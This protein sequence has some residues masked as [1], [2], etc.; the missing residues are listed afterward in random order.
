MSDDDE[1]GGLFG[2]AAS[3]GRSVRDNASDNES[4]SS[5]RAAS[6]PS[7]KSAKQPSSPKAPASKRQKKADGTPQKSAPR[8]PRKP[9]Q[10]PNTVDEASLKV[11]EV[12]ELAGGK[13]VRI[14]RLPRSRR[15]YVL[16]GI[17]LRD[18]SK[19][20]DQV[21]FWTEL[22]DAV[23]SKPKKVPEDGLSNIIFVR[24]QKKN[25]K[26]GPEISAFYSGGCLLLP[27][28]KWVLD[29]YAKISSILSRWI[30]DITDLHN[31]LTKIMKK[32]KAAADG[33][34]KFTEDDHK[35]HEQ[36]FLRLEDILDESNKARMYTALDL[37]L[38]FTLPPELLAHLRKLFGVSLRNH[39]DVLAGR[40][41]AAKTK[42]SKS[43]IE[44]VTTNPSR[45]PP[46]PGSVEAM[47]VQQEFKRKNA[48]WVQKVVDSMVR[49]GKVNLTEEMMKTPG[50]LFKSFGGESALAGI[51]AK[52]VKQQDGGSVFA[53][54]D[55]EELLR[56]Y[57][58]S[59]ET[60]LKIICL[61]SPTFVEFAFRHR[62]QLDHPE[63]E[64][65]A[66]ESK[67]GADEESGNSLISDVE[68]AMKTDADDD[69]GSRPEEKR[70][71]AAIAAAASSSSSAGKKRKHESSDD[72]SESDVAADRKRREEMMARKKREEKKKAEEFEKAFPIAGDKAK[73]STPKT[74]SEKKEAHQS[75]K[76]AKAKGSGSP[77]ATPQKSKPNGKKAMASSPES[78]AASPPKKNP[79]KRDSGGKAVTL[80]DRMRAIDVA[81]LTGKSDNG[82][83]EKQPTPQKKRPTPPPSPLKANGRNDKR[84]VEAETEEEEEE[85]EES[86]PS[87]QDDQPPE[88]E[89]EAVTQPL[90][91]DGG[92]DEVDEAAVQRALEAM[93]EGQ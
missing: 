13:K 1:S 45:S 20:Q 16:E 2:T 66:K 4:S 76:A 89:E 21:N 40:A 59:P 87:P 7:K 51:D 41:I 88:E 6:P 69:E 35:T 23:R 72:E 67:E 49:S 83:E 79:F 92:Q 48:E 61:D 26:E 53:V 38:H 17:E 27:P 39:R 91:D 63:A 22:L 68:E 93:E 12:V 15:R 5:R 14:T 85:E 33:K 25:D 34:G 90:D 32:R 10:P 52:E 78:P 60:Y 19:K 80:G 75:P 11:D 82:K 73:R 50:F 71:K 30:A 31:I 8:K 57:D 44:W 47:K 62:Y 18:E 55:V 3:G 37:K 29:Q 58:I 36:A 77:P 28:Q 64:T 81:S 9:D 65:G 74:M 56:K 70:P 54:P 46:Y 24:V 84:E 43:L 86:K 42:K